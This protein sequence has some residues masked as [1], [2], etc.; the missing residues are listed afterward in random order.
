MSA[1]HAETQR[2]KRVGFLKGPLGKA[3]PYLANARKKAM[4]SSD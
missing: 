4:S 2:V 3:P 1:R